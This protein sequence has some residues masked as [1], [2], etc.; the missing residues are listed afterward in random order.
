MKR[1]KE[2]KTTLNEKDDDKQ[3][4]D[5][6]NAFIS[7]PMGSYNPMNAPSAVDMISPSPANMVRMDMASN[8]GDV[9]YDNYINNLSPTQHMM[10]L[11][12]NPNIETV[13]VYDQNTGN[14]WFDVQDVTTGQSI[15][16][17]DRPDEMLVNDCIIDLNNGVARNSNLGVSYRLVLAGGNNNSAI[18]QY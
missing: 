18:N 1:M 17:T 10:L 9:Q 2:L 15:P 16:N 12:N 7:T 8:T 13:V 11:E 3:I 4:M 6:Y 14:R 5:M